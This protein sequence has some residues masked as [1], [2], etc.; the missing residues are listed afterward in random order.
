MKKIIYIHIPKCAGTSFKKHF[1]AFG[2]KTLLEISD[3]VNIK[4]YTL[5]TV[6]RNPYDRF[7]SAFYYLKN[8]GSFD[9]KN[10]NLKNKFMTLN[11]KEFINSLYNEFL[12]N[13]LIYNRTKN[14]D[15]FIN[16]IHFKP[17]YCF[18]NN[19]LIDKLIYFENLNK[20]TL[21][22]IDSNIY[23][24]LEITNKSSH[25]NY[26]EYFKELDTITINKFNNIYSRDFELFNYNKVTKF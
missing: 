25:K 9:K 12:Q 26:I 13:K 10:L 18:T 14:D 8:N 11:L 22:E 16:I 6:V 20:N 17:M 1:I 4:D 3:K 15:N 23:Q 19:N 21:K 2:H 7:I 24:E 5:L